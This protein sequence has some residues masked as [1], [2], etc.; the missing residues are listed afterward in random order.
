MVYD[1]RSSIVPYNYALGQETE[2]SYEN[3][4]AS[5]SPT[6]DG[7]REG[8]HWDEKEKFLNA[9]KK[10]PGAWIVSSSYSDEGDSSW[11]IDLVESESH[12]RHQLLRCAK[13]HGATELPSVGTEVVTDDGWSITN[14]SVSLS[15]RDEDEGSYLY[16]DIEIYSVD[17]FSQRHDLNDLS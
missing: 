12:A 1:Y 13:E 14:N 5:Y 2:M 6:H 10:H 3:Y 7:Y 8:Q 17:D 11:T 15:I 4:I 9:V 16:Q